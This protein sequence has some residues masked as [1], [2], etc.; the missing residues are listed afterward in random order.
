MPICPSSVFSVLFRIA[1]L[2]RIMN[3]TCLIL[4][5]D[6][7]SPSN[8]SNAASMR[9]VALQQPNNAVSWS[10]VRISPNGHWVCGNYTDV[11]GVNNAVVWHDQ[12]VAFTIAPSGDATEARISDVNDSGIAIGNFIAPG[13]MFG[14]YG[15]EK[16][17]GFTASLT[18]TQMLNGFISPNFSGTSAINNSGRIVGWAIEGG[19]HDAP[20]SAVWQY[21]VTTSPFNLHNALGFQDRYVSLESSWAYSVTESGQVLGGHYLPNYFAAY[22]ASSNYSLEWYGLMGDP[23]DWGGFVA[24][25]YHGDGAAGFKYGVINSPFV[26][27]LFTNSD[28]AFANGNLNGSWMNLDLR[29]SAVD[30]HGRV[31]GSRWSEGVIYANHTYTWLSELLSE[32]DRATVVKIIN[33]SDMTNS[34]IIAIQ[35][36]TKEGYLLA[37][38]AATSV[39]EPSTFVMALIGMALGALPFRRRSRLS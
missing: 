31:V 1:Y 32:Q 21:G 11:N 25:S 17:W 28:Q 24:T 27:G 15:G 4:A 19:W 9:L 3:I 7:F 5:I 30:D 39:P 29:P 12:K 13:P 6:F 20:R 23:P 36:S 33:A 8:A 34:G 14:T 38:V 26:N 22:Y 10:P 37:P 16:T 35:T 18:S 2:L